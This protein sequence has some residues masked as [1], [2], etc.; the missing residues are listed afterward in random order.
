MAP[1]NP[2]CKIGIKSWSERRARRAGS[3]KLRATEAM[4]MLTNVLKLGLRR[5]WGHLLG[6][7]AGM[8]PY[9]KWRALFNQMLRYEYLIFVIGSS[10]YHLCAWSITPTK[11]LLTVLCTPPHRMAPPSRRMTYFSKRSALIDRKHPT[12]S[13]R[14]WYSYCPNSPSTRTNEEPPTV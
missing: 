4:Y 7:W 10:S 1:S 8:R 9:L 11:N 13:D 3:F 5:N 2:C 14:S 12:I 6:I